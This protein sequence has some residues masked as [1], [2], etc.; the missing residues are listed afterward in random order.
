MCFAG[1]GIAQEH[2]GF[3][4]IDP[5]A[6]GE[7]RQRRWRQVGQLGGVEVFEAFRSGK[8]GFFDSAGPAAIVALFALV[9]E[10]LGEVAGVGVVLPGDRISERLGDFM[11]AGHGEGFAGGGDR[12][13]RGRV[14]DRRGGGPR[15]PPEG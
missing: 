4:V 8:A 2:G 1:S 7:V 13:V 6:I 12:G 9:G 10:E 5:G 15:E 11:D 3:A 14:G